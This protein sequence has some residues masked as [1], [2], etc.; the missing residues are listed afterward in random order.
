M[1][2]C[3]ALDVFIGGSILKM[4]EN[5]KGEVVFDSFRQTHP[6]SSCLLFSELEFIDFSIDFHYR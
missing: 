6:R 4:Q 3:N 1:G 5:Q 2:K